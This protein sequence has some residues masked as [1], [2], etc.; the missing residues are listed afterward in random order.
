METAPLPTS[1]LDNIKERPPFPSLQTK[2]GL[3]I[4]TAFRT[5]LLPVPFF[6]F[7]HGSV[8]RHYRCNRKDAFKIPNVCVISD[9]PPRK[10]PGL[11]LETIADRNGLPHAGADGK[12]TSQPNKYK[13][14]KKGRSVWE[15]LTAEPSCSV[16][17]TRVCQR[18]GGR[19]W[20]RR[21]NNTTREEAEDKSEKYCPA[22]PAH[23]LSI[24][25]SESRTHKNQLESF[26][27]ASPWRP[28]AR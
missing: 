24:C 20:R 9:R 16:F 13:C 15:T 28:T 3:S 27:A 2:K 5:K 6:V 14:T 10:L 22:L 26:V 1:E 21:T 4:S 12:S 17:G 18:G 11:V 25:P 8:V 23:A 19:E 7:F